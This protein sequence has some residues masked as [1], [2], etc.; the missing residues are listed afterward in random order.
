MRFITMPFTLLA[1]E[2][3]QADQR[4]CEWRSAFASTAIAILDAL[5]EDL[6]LNSDAERQE[7]AV[8][9]LQNYTFLYKDVYEQNGKV[10]CKFLYSIST[11]LQLRFS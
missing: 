1:R 4:V 9:A 5:F 10:R 7:F 11:N 8:S 6:G 2:L 3:I